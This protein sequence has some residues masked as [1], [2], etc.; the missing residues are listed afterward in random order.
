MPSTYQLISSNVLTSNSASVNFSA[1][2][3]TYTDLMLR[4]SGRTDRNST[5]DE[6]K[7]VFNSDTATN[8]SQ[9]RIGGTGSAAQTERL[10]GFTSIVSY[11]SLDGNTATS[12][13]F[14][15]IEI[16]IPSYTVS[17]NKPLRL[18]GAQE[19][20]DSI[21]YIN[22]VAGLWRNTSAITSIVLTSSN[23]ANFVSGSSFYL[24]GI[25][26]S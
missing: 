12:N 22:A 15:S 5:N 16:Y 21:A 26:N 9:T 18:F 20:N 6:L 13:T 14:G 8:Y 19:N 7:I 25:K 4:I 10:S 3:S 2:P 24:Y 1:I 23:A 17:Q 11:L